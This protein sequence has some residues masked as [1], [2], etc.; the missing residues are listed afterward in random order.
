MHSQTDGSALTSSKKE[1]ENAFAERFYFITYDRERA[2][3]GQGDEAVQ[4]PRPEQV[5]KMT[6]KSIVIVYELNLTF[7]KK[8]IS[9]FFN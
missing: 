2:Q 9:Q 4:E 8:W 6:R 1:E 7:A 5:Q 3:V